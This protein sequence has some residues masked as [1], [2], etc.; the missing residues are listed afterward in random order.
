MAFERFGFDRLKFSW[1]HSSEEPNVPLQEAIQPNDCT[2]RSDNGNGYYCDATQF[3][4]QLTK[5]LRFI[6]DDFLPAVFE[7]P[8]EI[9]NA[10]YH[11]KVT[12]SN[13]SEVYRLSKEQISIFPA[14]L[15]SLNYFV[16][17]VGKDGNLLDY[18]DSGECNADL[19]FVKNTMI[20]KINSLGFENAFRL[21]EQV[22][23]SLKECGEPFIHNSIVLVVDE[24]TTLPL[25]SRISKEFNGKRY[26]RLN[27][28]MELYNKAAS[29]CK[30]VGEFE[31]CNGF[32]IERRLDPVGQMLSDKEIES[33][34]WK[35]IS[36]SRTQK[37][38]WLQEFELLFKNAHYV[39][40]V[41]NN[42]YLQEF[43]QLVEFVKRNAAERKDLV[44]E[45]NAPFNEFFPW[46]PF[47]VNLKQ[48]SI[49]ND[50]KSDFQKVYPREL[51]GV[52]INDISFNFFDN[53]SQESK[54][55]DGF[56]AGKHEIE[57]KAV[58]KKNGENYSLKEIEISA[59]KFTPLFSVNQN[60]ARNPFFYMPFDG[61][62]GTS[63]FL[64]NPNRNGYGLSYSGKKSIPLNDYSTYFIRSTSGNGIKKLNYSINNS[65][66]KACFNGKTMEIFNGSDN[67]Y[68]L[69]FNEIIP[70]A[71]SL[72]ST[73]AGTLYY[74]Y[75]NTGKKF[76]PSDYGQQQSLIG[77][78]DGS[79][80]LQNVSLPCSGSHEIAVVKRIPK[81]IPQNNPIKAIAF[82]PIGTQLLIVCFDSAPNAMASIELYRF[83][84]KQEKQTIH[85][86]EYMKYNNDSVLSLWSNISGFSIARYLQE[87]KN[88]KMCFHLSDGIGQRLLLKWNKDFFLSKAESLRE[89]PIEFNGCNNSGLEELLNGYSQKEIEASDFALYR[90]KQAEFYEIPNTQKVPDPALNAFYGNYYTKPEMQKLMSYLKELF[91]YYANKINAMDFRAIKSN[92]SF[93]VDSELAFA[94]AWKESRFNPNAK[95]YTGAKGLMQLMNASAIAQ[96]KKFGIN[97]QNPYNVCE[98]IQGGI[99][100]LKW[101]YDNMWWWNNGELSRQAFESLSEE[102]KEEIVI[103]AYNKGKTGVQNIPRNA[104]R[105][106]S[107]KEALQALRADSTY[108][109]YTTEILEFLYSL[110]GKKYSVNPLEDN[111][112]NAIETGNSVNATVYAGAGA[113]TAIAVSVSIV[114]Y[115]KRIKA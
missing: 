93:N 89:L 6:E 72:Y 86:N 15:A 36:F 48:D 77:W 14:E 53:Y 24:K 17:F 97:V 38:T 66:N 63:A 84:G 30:N 113:I 59:K 69:E 115:F 73:S 62:L 45:F 58:I 110:K 11:A 7:A 108:K 32:S 49:S 102:E 10:V 39:V 75:Y 47:T 4:I 12:I 5:D 60:Y 28:L 64:L 91:F 101:L 27:L 88:G 51:T 82:V 40:G 57:I 20:E 111:S 104:G 22:D 19:S 81:A 112:V 65:F 92:T 78:S 67:S 95:S 16:F 46:E 56:Q 71:L 99:A 29:A 94:I 21:N 87:I 50:F 8:V 90:K 100:Y 107:S 105:T 37:R 25:L 80:S 13:L 76:S 109:T 41:S 52:N 74:Q 61:K 55:S 9:K 68:L 98:N 2:A 70:A 1:L 44:E 96:V 42:F 34:F 18:R 54:A 103:T 106:S 26:F 85:A 83:D 33:G 23:E 79:D 35:K 3:S 43:P 114:F 31:D